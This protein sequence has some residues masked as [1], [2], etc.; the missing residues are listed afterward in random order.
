[1]TGK[2]APLGVETATAQIAAIALRRDRAA[3][4][5]L[6]AHFA[7]RVKAYGLRLG[8]SPAAADDLAQETLLAVWQK[9]AYFDPGKAG[10]A[11]WIF[12]IARN[13]R[14]D[15][16]RRERY[17]LV[18]DGDP[19]LV[20]DDAPAADEAVA[21]AEG[22]QR[23]RQALGALPQEQAAVVRL[24]FFDDK[25]HGEIERDLGIPLG[26]VKSRLRLALS[27]LRLLLEG[28]A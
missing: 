8:A 12:T 1:V 13:L 24:S 22:A 10:A 19:L 2:A 11:T 28:T 14:I 3:F 18:S 5:A 6:F 27:R 23:L 16:L 9:A 26:T 17:P 25:P 4:A 21:T 7:P 20:V 15:A